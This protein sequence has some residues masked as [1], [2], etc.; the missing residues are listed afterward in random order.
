MRA[1]AVRSA[2]LFVLFVALAAAFVL[3][4]PRGQ[5][6]DARL[7]WVATAH[8]FGP[9][10]YRD[11]AG[12]ISPDGKWIAYSEG[13]YLRVRPVDGGPIVDLPPGP[14]QI[15]YL[16]WRPDGRAIA[17]DG[18]PTVGGYAV[19]DITTRTRGPLFYPALALS[20]VEGPS[21]LRQPVWSPDGKSIAAL[22]NA[23]EGNELW[24]FPA[25]GDGPA[26]DGG[27]GARVR[28][29]SGAA[30]FPV[31]TPAGEIACVINANGQSRVTLPCG[32][33]TVH[34]NPDAD[35]YGPIAFSPDAATLYVALA[36]DRGTVGLWAAPMT[37]RRARRLTSFARDAYAPSVAADGSVLF[38]VQSYRTAVA[39][40]AAGGGPT[41]P[42]STFQSETPSWD[43]TGHA[44]GITFGSWRRIPDDARY[45]DI[46][47]D[48]GIIGV[49]PS[50]PAAAAS[51][52]VHDSTS[53]DQS[54]CW[55]PNGKWI[56]FHSH[57][58][59]SDDI[60]LRPSTPL[61]LSPSKDESLRAGPSTPT[62]AESLR[63]GA[64][65]ARRISF[66]GRGAETGWPRWSP[67][68][69]WLLFDGASRDT[70]RSVFYVIGMDQESGSTKG[71]AIEIAVRGLGAEMSHAEWLPD[72]Q[73][74]VAIAKESPGRHVIFTVSRD[75]GDAEIVHR[76]ASEHDAP[77]LAVSPDG[78]AVAFIAPAPDG[79][80]QLFRLPLGGDAT[81]PV[82]ITRDPSNKT[83]PAW[84]PD[85]ARIA[86]TVWNYDAQFWRLR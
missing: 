3:F 70:H 76:L 12:A 39:I 47:Q 29:L 11:P 73:G 49:D 23:R 68:G 60:W 15:R 55:S 83:Q 82:Q 1:S 50:H 41:S 79:F 86:F 19:Y 25:A 57:K 38:K 61:I 69:E 66:L 72:S 32:G 5:V 2:L 52:V 17:T 48:A 36:N 34:T 24:R 27:R 43:P 40:V 35:A 84:S 30:S 78:G 4:L 58:D 6:S 67:D 62:N 64:T 21:G 42:L 46:A 37:G 33:A 81:V 16:T 28:Q 13:R 20:G 8:Q 77:G 51:Q 31:W 14:A 80:F 44:L 22:V 71:D 53:E 85:G 10:G 26:I 54:L 59:Q 9:V 56:A 45:P 18:D 74:I 63:A 75:G 7:A 65:E